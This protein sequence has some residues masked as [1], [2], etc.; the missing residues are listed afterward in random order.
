MSNTGSALPV[1]HIQKLKELFPQVRLFSMYGLTE[2]KRVS[3]LPPEELEKRPGSVGV[4]MPNCEVFIVDE[5][6]NELAAGEIGELVIRGSNVMRGYWNSPELTE[7]TY[8]QGILPGEKLLYNDQFMMIYGGIA[9]LGLQ[10]YGGISS[11]IPYAIS[12]D[13]IKEQGIPYLFKFSPQFSVYYCENDNCNQINISQTKPDPK[14]PEI[15]IYNGRKVTRD[16]KCFGQCHYKYP[17]NK[18]QIPSQISATNTS[19]ATSVSRGQPDGA[20]AKVSFRPACP[21]P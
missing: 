11:L 12:L 17:V 13:E 1:N 5:D 21:S 18:S 15:S 16:G 3:Y 4:P 20:W 10:I 14:N 19:S 9:I 6:C 2:C 7:K 8:R